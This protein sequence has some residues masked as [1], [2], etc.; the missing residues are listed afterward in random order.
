[1][2][3]VTLVLDF[4]K[5]LFLNSNKQSATLKEPNETLPEPKPERAYLHL[6]DLIT[7]SGKYPDRANHPELTPEVISNL[8]QL[9]KQ[10]TALLNDLGVDHV[11]VSSGFR[12][13]TVNANIPNAAKKSLHMI[14]KAVDLA[15]PTNSLDKLIESHPELLEKHGLWLE[16]PLATP[17]WAHL[18][19]GTRSARKIRIFIP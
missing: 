18:D 1:M 17:S 16:S 19:I 9:L 15:D 8:E 5:I 4:L 13:S 3:I 12:P 11:E 10:V 6:S 7:S 14:G 2:V